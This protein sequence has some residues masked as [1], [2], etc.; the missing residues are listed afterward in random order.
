ME[1][2]AFHRHVRRRR[3]HLEEVPGDRLALTILVGCEIELVGRLQ[4]LLE[5]RDLGLLLLGHDVQRLEVVLDVDAQP[6]PRFALH[7]RRHLR[8]VA[9]QIPDVT[10]RRF[11]DEIAPGRA[12]IGELEPVAGR[13]PAVRGGDAER[14]DH[15]VQ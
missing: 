13:A 1:H 8:R 10:D 6:G 5:P 11:H 14:P 7:R 9:G 4:E 12:E 3:Q 15:G 2:H